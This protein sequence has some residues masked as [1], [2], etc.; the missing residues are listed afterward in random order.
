MK[1]ILGFYNSG[2]A[3]QADIFHSFTP[4]EWSQPT[5]AQMS[6]YLIHTLPDPQVPAP[7]PSGPISSTRPAGYS[8]AAIKLMG[9]KKDIKREIAAYPSLKDERYFDSFK[10]SLF[11]VAKSH[12]CNEILDP[13][14]NPGSAPE[15]LELFEAKTF[16]FSAFNA[17]LQT[18]K[19]KTIV[20]RHL[21]T[22]DAQSVWRE[23]S[24]HM[25]TSSKGASEKEDSPNLDDNLK[26]TTEQFVLHFNEEF[27]QLD[28]ISDDSKKLPPTVKLTL[29]QTAVR[30]I[31][32][33]RIVETLDEFQSTTHG[34]GSS[35]S[36]SYQTHYDLLKANIGKKRNV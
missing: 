6:T 28:E 21:A 7:V 15:Q 5:P 14:Y 35:T 27:R 18:N 20:R 13:T 16:M 17:N 36:L 30:S 19:G 25:R 22:T 8:T 11:I 3:P 4:D 2:I 33:L 24:E 23:L 12:K 9:F 10:G 26:G 1:N 34:H 31:I 32:D 29:L